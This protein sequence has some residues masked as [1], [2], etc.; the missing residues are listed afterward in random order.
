ML[1]TFIVAL[2]LALAC[3]KQPLQTEHTVAASSPVAGSPVAAAPVESGLSGTVAEKIDTTQYSY[4]R[5]TTPSGEIWAAVPKSKV[6]VGAQ[7]TILGASWMQDFESK[8]LARTWSRIA[9]GTLEGEAQAAPGMGASPRPAAG[10]AS[11]GGMFA[12]EAAQVSPEQAPPAP[13]P[14]AEFSGPA[15][16]KV[17]G[18]DGHSIA[19]IYAKRAALKDQKVAV[20][21]KVVKATNGVMGKNW[22][23]LRD[24]SGAGASADLT[25]A[26]DSTT[27][28]VGDVVL[29]TGTVHL[30]RDLGSGYR[31][32]V[33][34]EDA[35]VKKE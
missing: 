10:R 23:H 35:Q 8:T 13:V 29:M 25:V 4:L 12:Q 14:S 16:H 24:G 18:R 5:L 9:F 27:A 7:A 21:G 17:A 11:G 20:R 6:A 31:Y 22:L 34:V 15:L 1:R 19:E 3:A 2:A 28:S 26:S 33:L 30:D 32:D